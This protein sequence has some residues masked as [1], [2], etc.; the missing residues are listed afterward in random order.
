[1]LEL[2]SIEAD[3]AH[4]RVR[5]LIEE[6]GPGARLATPGYALSGGE[7]RR[8]EIARALALAAALHAAST[9][10]SPESTRSPSGNCS[11]PSSA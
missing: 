4:E 1:V 11:A 3:T 9:S 5:T 10:R 6:F 8:V 7:R 2:T